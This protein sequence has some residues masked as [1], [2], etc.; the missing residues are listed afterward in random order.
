MNPTYNPGYPPYS[1]YQDAYTTPPPPPP[2]PGPQRTTW[3]QQQQHHTAPSTPTWSRRSPTFPAHGHRPAPQPEHP[4]TGYELLAAKLSGYEPSTPIQPIY[5]RFEALNHRVMLGLQDDLTTLEEQLRRLDET[6][7]ESRVHL[8]GYL[9]ASRRLEAMEPTELTE[10][11]QDLIRTI[12]Y[13]LFQYNTQISA[14][15]TTA[16]L[17]VPSAGAIAE[18]KEFLASHGPIVPTEARFLEREDDL[19]CLFDTTTFPEQEVPRA[20]MATPTPERMLK[21]QEDN[22]PPSRDASKAVQYAVLGALAAIG[23]PMLAFQFIP[24]FIARMTIVLL[25][26]LFAFAV[27]TC[28]GT[29]AGDD[30]RSTTDKMYLAV[31]YGLVMAIIA[32]TSV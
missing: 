5:R 32:S 19:V 17:A 10:A 16:S 4:P 29:W 6:D 9:P 21:A 1:R 13:Q 25:V 18:Y 14:I 22:R 30:D 26:G 27:L 11:R 24:W 7:S 12:A 28:T 15:K 2:P 8:D 3:Q 31:V 23:V 20:G